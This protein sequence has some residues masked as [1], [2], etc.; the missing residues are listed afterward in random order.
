MVV[1]PQVAQLNLDET[2]EWLEILYAETPGLVNICST[3]NFAGQCFASSDIDG[4]LSYAEQLDLAGKEGIYLRATTLSQEPEPGRRGG[5]GLSSHLPGL[6]AD[7]D[8]E[9]PGH[10]HKGPLRL[11]PDVDEAMR[12]VLESGL[13]EPSHW[14]HS[15]GGL[16]PWWLLREPAHIDDLEDFQSLS[17]GWQE[18]LG[19]SA[20]KLGYHYGTEVG[21]LSRVLRLPGT[22]NRKAGLER[23]CTALVGHA[24]SGRVYE[25]SELFDALAANT[26]EPPAPKPIELKVQ[27]NLDASG[28]KPG[29]DF[30]KRVSWHD[31]L[32]D[33]GWQF[34]RKTGYGWILRR[35]GK[36][37]GEGS[38]TL[39]D[40]TGN[41][42]IFSTE[43][44][45]P[46]QARRHY[47]K[48]AYFTYT[49]HNGDFT[50]S[51][52]YLSA[53]GFGT[54]LERSSQSSGS[55]LLLDSVQATGGQSPVLA[56]QDQALPD[57]PPVSK[58]TAIERDHL[59]LPVY[60]DERLSEQPW[61]QIGMA[62]LWTD[63]YR[64]SF[65][66]MGSQKYWARWDDKTWGQDEAGLHGYCASVMM[67]RLRNHSRHIAE[68]DPELG[69]NLTRK[70]EKLGTNGAIESV[71][72]IASR[73]P[74]IACKAS[75]FDKDPNLMTLSNGTL[76]LA[77]GK[78]GPHDPRHM[79]TRLVNAPFVPDAKTGRWTEFMEQVM[80]DPEVRQYLQRVCGYMLTGTLNERIMILVHGESGTGKTQFLEAI[81]GVLG[82]FAG[83]A[84][85]SAF[86]PRVA[87]Y[88]GPSE[89]L[90]KLKGKRFV[91][92]SELDA[93]SKLNESLVK[94]IIGGDTQTT[95]PLYGDPVDWNPEYT[96]F[97]ATNYLPRISSS[98]NAIWNRVKPVKFEQ[99]FIDGSGQALDPDS[100]NI[101]RKMAQEEPEVIL[102]WL[103]EGLAAYREHGLEEPEKVKAW[104]NEYREEVDTTRQFINEAPEEGRI[105]VEPGQK[106]ASREL[107]KAYVAWCQD[108]SIMPLGSKT[109]SERMASNGFERK[110]VKTGSQWEGIGLVG[111]IKDAQTPAAGFHR[112][113]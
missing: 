32:L 42:F 5:D 108:N 85:A 48:W 33:D 24:W 1:V 93:G 22:I 28:T 9:G 111:W 71:L 78:L 112:R 38:A 82:D 83:V 25:L 11:P 96:V 60:P 6:W 62:R 31:L 13:P 56:Q 47:S 36:M 26:P 46:L 35:P 58:A 105:L 90:H 73:D 65:A 29:D 86:Q 94:S 89:D 63:I 51:A 68:Q 102:N 4:I 84:P 2:R 21:D 77:T 69:K 41:L 106:V 3:G 30:N 80:P 99:V 52:K 97:L 74:R 15:G 53:K 17:Q 72:K 66:F 7:V 70:A 75:D 101:G 27:R 55:K 79:L 100:R 67:E 54:P 98:D 103:L 87:G 19:A 16:Y 39:W 88:K 37:R 110:H 113:T 45:Y 92:Q 57:S 49:R 95:R 64:D 109:F 50:A 23:P 20:K 44:P 18:I 40:S 14:I 104:L 8:I 43:A 91:I 59:G 107:Y 34:I 76:N 10:K 61:D 12:I 81:K